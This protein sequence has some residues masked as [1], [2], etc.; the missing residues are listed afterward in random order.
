MARAIASK[1]TTP[2]CPQAREQGH[3]QQASR[4]MCNALDPSWLSPIPLSLGG[5]RTQRLRHYQLKTSLGDV[6]PQGEV[7]DIA[8]FN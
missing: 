8:P 7:G 3:D 5:V 1:L 6:F 2:A 4:A